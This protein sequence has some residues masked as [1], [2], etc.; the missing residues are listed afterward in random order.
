MNRTLAPTALLLFLS[1]IAICQSSSQV[2]DCSTLKYVRH[3]VSC[4]CG[5]VAVCSGDICVGPSAF[6]LDNEIDVVLRDKHARTLQS[7]TLSYDTERK[8]C[9]EG[10]R[11]GEY[12]IAF[13][14]H[15]KRA[16]QPAVMFPVS[17]KE[18]SKK[19]CDS[20]YMV[21]PDCPK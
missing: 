9:F 13:V 21:E 17:F 7:K 16:A 18:A 5:E 6:G 15:K 11:D 4:L 20:T 3:K 8:F 14:T 12:Q 1:P 10:Q 2:S 19:A